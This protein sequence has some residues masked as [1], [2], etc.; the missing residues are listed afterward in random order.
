M[1][2]ATQTKSE[3]KYEKFRVSVEEY[4]NF[5]NNG[6]LVLKGLV[7]P[8]DIAELREHTDDL[9]NGRLPEQQSSFVT[10]HGH[11]LQIPENL[12]PE[13]KVQH[14]LRI[15][16]L[17]R[18][19]ALH[20]KYLL[21]P[22]VLDGLEGL[23]GPDI[24]AMQTMLFLKPPGKPGQGWH[25][26]SFYIPT[27]PDTLI[28]AWIAIDD[29]DEMNGA[30]WFA[31]GSQVEP[32]YPPREGYGF[33]ERVLSDITSVKGVSE[34]DDEQNDLHKVA[35][36]YPNVLVS[37]KA[38]DVVFF[39]GHVLHRSKKNFSTDRFRRAFV[40]HYCSARSF[41]QWGADEKN[42]YLPAD[43]KT[44]ITTNCNILARG[45]THLP[46]GLPR[47]NT[48]CAALQTEEERCKRSTWARS[49]M[50][51]METGYMGEG[52]MNPD[53]DHDHEPEMPAQMK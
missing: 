21:H 20:E 42:G 29:C 18:H 16:M 36:K 40:S 8:E 53:I 26:D 24:S 43:K 5:K 4:L 51:N 1:V 32:I 19:L 25:Q 14:F 31:Q 38:G 17:H 2:A 41:T 28:G 44:G 37:A 49:T 30:M 39:G 15:H 10:A 35:Q 33:G 48:P 45:D 7:P 3:T 12:S 6:F 22:R 52:E 23:I 13:E 47:F 50:A 11:T 46:F 34:V 9:M 27:F